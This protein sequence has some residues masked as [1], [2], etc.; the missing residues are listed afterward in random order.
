MR[1]VSAVRGMRALRVTMK[2][3]KMR[4]MRALMGSKGSGI[5]EDKKGSE[6]R[7]TVRILWQDLNFLC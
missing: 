3:R 7:R 4:T 5:I 1:K 2:V 6:D